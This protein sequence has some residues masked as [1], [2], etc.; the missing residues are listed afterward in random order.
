[1]SEKKLRKMHIW[2]EIQDC[3]HKTGIEPEEDSLTL[4][5]NK[6]KQEQVKCYI[7]STEINEAEHSFWT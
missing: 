6:F 3:E 7:G 5:W 4:S 2:N 1:M